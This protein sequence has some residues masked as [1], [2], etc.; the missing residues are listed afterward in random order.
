MSIVC[1]SLVYDCACIYF[2]C[3][4]LL[5]PVILKSTFGQGWRYESFERVIV[6]EKQ[7]QRSQCCQIFQQ[8]HRQVENLKSPKVAQQ[9]FHYFQTL[10]V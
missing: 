9:Y 2:I 10:A 3:T 6:V 8:S 4:H 7:S 5:P 1:V